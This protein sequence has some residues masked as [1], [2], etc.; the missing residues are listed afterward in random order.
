LNVSNESSSLII[1]R[2]PWTARP[3]AEDAPAVSADYCRAREMAERAAA[4]RASSVKAR[5][6]HQ[7]LA[8]A[9]ARLTGDGRAE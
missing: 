1:F 5:R 7:E 8:Q 9:Y 4:K 3:E 6:V 2:A